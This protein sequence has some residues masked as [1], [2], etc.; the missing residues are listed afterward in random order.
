MIHFWRPWAAVSRGWGIPTATDIAADLDM[1]QSA[2]H[3][4][5]EKLK[6]PVDLGLFLFAFTQAG[7]PFADVGPMSWLVLSSL[8]LGKVIGVGA[9]GLLAIRLGFPLPAG[10]D[11]RDLLMAGFIAAVGLTVALFVATAAF[12]RSRGC[13]ARRRWA[14][15][16]PVW[17]ASLRSP[18]AAR[19]R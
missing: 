8:V 11:Q 16:S 19:F 12:P 2:L 3:D 9:M 10:M 5:E 13:R 4:F 1:E 18:W 15:S 7:V 6:L 17:R 14:R